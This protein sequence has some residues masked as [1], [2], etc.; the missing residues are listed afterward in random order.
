MVI[1]LYTSARDHLETRQTIDTFVLGG[2]SWASIE[3]DVEEPYLHPFEEDDN[4]G[5]GFVFLIYLSH[6]D[7]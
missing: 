7:L 4:S 3:H 5:E 2:L 1:K 6:T